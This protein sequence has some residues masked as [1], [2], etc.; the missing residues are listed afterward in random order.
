MVSVGA[1]SFF[2]ALEP[3]SERAAG[4]F[5]RRVLLKAAPGAAGV[6]CCALSAMLA[7]Y[8]GT[9]D[10]IASTMAVLSAG[11]IGLSNLILTCR[12]F[13]KLRIAICT[14]MCCGF[15]AAAAFLPG[16]FKLSVAAMTARHW[17][18]LAAITAAGVMVLILVTLAVRPLLKKL[19]R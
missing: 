5:L 2:L 18:M 8:F 10:G 1:P 15:A 13:S 3:S 12:P 14:A 9:P 4:H 17:I 6:V 11:V 19:E 16:L 7:N